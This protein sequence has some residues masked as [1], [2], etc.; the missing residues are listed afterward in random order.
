LS[1]DEAA[2]VLGVQAN[3]W[4]E[5]IPKPERLQYMMFPRLCALAEVA[6]T[7]PARKDSAQFHKRLDAMLERLRN[8]GI[9]FRDPHQDPGQPK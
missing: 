3:V 5:V 4:T 7:P 1:P 2:H 8:L 9:N 6:W